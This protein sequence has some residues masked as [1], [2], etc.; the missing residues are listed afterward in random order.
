[1]NG[2]AGKGDSYRKVDQKK[3]GEGYDRAFK[4]SM[5]CVLTGSTCKVCTKKKCTERRY[6]SI[7][8]T[9]DGD[10]C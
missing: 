1:M 4:K 2:E 8:K 9:E 10:L 5:R 3:Y 7:I 6:S